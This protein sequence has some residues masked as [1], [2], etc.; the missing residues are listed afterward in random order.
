MN[1]ENNDLGYECDGC[2]KIIQKGKA[3]VCISKNIEQINHEVIS[4]EEE[5]EVISSENL[6]VLCGKCGNKFDDDFFINIIKNFPLFGN[7]RSN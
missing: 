2:G 7:Q 3:Y 6:L 1:S 5:V 4:N